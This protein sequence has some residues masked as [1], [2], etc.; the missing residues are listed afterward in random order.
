[1]NLQ[2]EEIFREKIRL[3]QLVI[4][5]TQE[6][7]ALRKQLEQRSVDDE[8]FV[9][10]LQKWLAKKQLSVK[11]STYNSYEN[12]IQTHIEPFFQC[13]KLHLSEITS[14][15]LERYFRIKFQSGLSAATLSKQHSIIHSVL[16]DAVKKKLLQS[17]PADYAEVPSGEKRSGVFLSAK[18]L[19]MLFTRLEGD[20]LLTPV[21]LA[22]VMGL[23]R[24]EALG[25]RWSDVD[26]D[27]KTI[28]IQHTV[29]K[30]VKNHHTELLFSD[31]MKTDSS[32]RTL[33][34]PEQLFEY[35]KY[36]KRRQCQLYA[37]NH[38]TY[39]RKYL[40]YICVDRFGNILQ[41]DY[42][43]KAFRKKADSLNL[44]CRF[45]DLRHT[46]ASLLYQNG[47]AM[48]SVS[49]WLGHSSTAVTD[50]IYIHL[51]FKDKE[52][53]ADKLEEIIKF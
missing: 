34:C 21:M 37:E 46:C 49:E 20:K 47:V 45:H 32:R 1:M 19:H 2:F 8:L 16:S 27:N 22:G 43:S 28:C 18:Q 33:P 4:E 39:N 9:S 38:K 29:T 26:W 25:L 11:A 35:L 23:R 53:V 36:I 52:S 51:S 3:S 14:D 10:F 30:Y 12:N 48:K 17:N 6:N 41:P 31:V 15:V 50:S 5:L 42:V 44:K 40:K 13:E 7:R 24:S